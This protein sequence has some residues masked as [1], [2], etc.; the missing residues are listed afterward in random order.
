MPAASV[1]N[2]P[3]PIAQRNLSSFYSPQSGSISS[4]ISHIGSSRSV[5][6]L[7]ISN[8]KIAKKLNGG[9]DQLGSG[10]S[11]ENGAVHSKFR[12]HCENLDSEQPESRD[13]QSH[14]DDIFS[15]RRVSIG[16][17][18]GGR[19]VGYGYSPVPNKDE[20]Q[21]QFSETYPPYRKPESESKAEAV[22]VDFSTMKTN[23]IDTSNLLKVPSDSM[24]EF[25]LEPSPSMASNYSNSNNGNSASVSKT[26]ESR[27]MSEY[28]SPSY[29]RGILG[30]RSGRPHHSSST[31]IDDR[32]FKSLRAPELPP[33]THI[34]YCQV[35]QSS[36][37]NNKANHSI[38][39][40]WTH[41]SPSTKQAAIVSGDNAD[42]DTVEYFDLDGQDQV[43]EPCPLKSSNSRSEKWARRFTRRKESRHISI[44]HQQDS[45]QASSD[46]YEDCESDGLLQANS[47]KSNIA[48]D[49]ASMY[50][51]CIEMPGSFDGSRWASR[52]SRMLWD[53]CTEGLWHSAG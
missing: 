1:V 14:T 29:L 5:D 25:I 7:N 45:S 26:K 11:P 8:P 10:H 12:E 36:E 6:E 27:S 16:W 47:T 33:M 42:D 28:A 53:A 18:S 32:G 31:R 44:L 52:K 41:L 49:L 30:S 38:S 17:M 34:E 35:P 13:L 48:E 50:Q 9:S 15:P 37:Y 3:N 40:R 51:D 4:N 23:G 20:A 39:Q 2:S 22:P 43:H 24:E 19:R 46:P 21:D